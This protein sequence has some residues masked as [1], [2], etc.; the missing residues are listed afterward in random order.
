MEIVPDI[1]SFNFSPLFSRAHRHLRSTY[2][3]P[4]PKLKH[5]I[6]LIEKLY[7]RRGESKPPSLKKSL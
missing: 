2:L 4:D 6:D 7:W 1:E 3:F 5:G